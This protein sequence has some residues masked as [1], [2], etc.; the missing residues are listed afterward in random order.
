MPQKQLSNFAFFSAGKAPYEKR[1]D[2]PLREWL[3]G[4]YVRAPLRSLCQLPF[5]EAINR[6]FPS[7]SSPRPVTTSWFE[8]AG[9]APSGG[10]PDLG[11]FFGFGGGG[12]E[13]TQA[14][15]PAPALAKPPAPSQL[16]EGTTVAP[17]TRQQVAAGRIT[18]IE[19][20]EPPQARTSMDFGRSSMDMDMVG[21]RKASV[22]K[23]RRKSSVSRLIKETAHDHA[24]EQKDTKACA[25][26]RA[27]PHRSYSL[28][29]TLVKSLRR[30]HAPCF[31]PWGACLKP[32]PRPLVRAH[33]SSAAHAIPTPC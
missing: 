17:P 23:R 2:A 30:L 16:E 18:G 25:K 12:E 28:V 33:G 1:A 24:G 15:A 32:A 9:G 13:T 14:A 11:R 7:A 5:P 20:C 3:A 10:T 27:L 19:T 6:A 21:G 26:T 4:A 8:M 31:L 29:A 22:N